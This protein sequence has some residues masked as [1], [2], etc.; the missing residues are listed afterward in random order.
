MCW[1]PAPT[2]SPASRPIEISGRCIAA[3]TAAPRSKNVGG[4]GHGPAQRADQL[5]RGR[6]QQ[7][8][9]ALCRGHRTDCLSRR[10]CLNRALRERRFRRDLVPGVRRGA[11]LRAI[12]PGRQT[13]LKIATG[14]GGAVAVGVIEY[15][16]KP[17]GTADGS[18]VTGLFWSGD[19]G[20]NWRQL[21]LPPVTEPGLNRDPSTLQ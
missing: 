7:S 21:P 11:K 10:Q 17:D 19:S 8:K 3:R 20:T 4:C 13:I 16:I 6:P 2:K 18:A 15:K 14:P 9:Q 5:D 1:W 12:H